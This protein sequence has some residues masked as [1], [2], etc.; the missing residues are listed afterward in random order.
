MPET[1]GEGMKRGTLSLAAMDGTG[2]KSSVNVGVSSGGWN[3]VVGG[4]YPFFKA[5]HSCG[6]KAS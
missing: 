6:A 5:T 4:A 2:A 1:G 3:A